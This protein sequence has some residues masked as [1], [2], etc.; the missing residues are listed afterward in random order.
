MPGTQLMTMHLE[1]ITNEQRDA[2]RLLSPLLTSRQMYLAGGTSL[3]LQFGHRRSVD[4][5]WFSR[6]PI[7]DPMAL[8]QQLR[9][10]EI[11]FET[12]S[13]ARGTLHGRVLGVPVSL[14]EFGYPLL[15][16]PLDWPE[17]NCCLASPLDLAAMKLVA[18]AQ[19]GS[20]KDFVDIYALGQQQFSLAEMLQAYQEKYDVDDIARIL[21]SLTYFDDADQEPNPLLQGDFS[22]DD[23]KQTIRAWVKAMA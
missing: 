7:A 15:R 10:A 16:P 17:M 23:C 6:Q 9:S 12:G 11:P 4:L 1:T 21:C 3:A 2:I 13:V 5:N 22:W 8:A 20:K 18:V 14:L 19:R